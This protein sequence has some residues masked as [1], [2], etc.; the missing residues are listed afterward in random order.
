MWETIRGYLTFTRKERFGV[1]FLLLIICILFVLP[2]IFRRPVGESDPAAYEKMKES[3]RNFEMKDSGRTMLT[4]EASGAGAFNPDATATG[5]QL[6]F[7]FDPN[8][9][10]S[11]D[12]KRLGISQRLSE[13]ITRYIE[14]GGRFRQR[15]DLKKIYGLSPAD[16]QR[17]SPFVQIAKKRQGS[18]LVKYQHPWRRDSGTSIQPSRFIAKRKLL[19]PTAINLADTADWAK[20]P[21][22]GNKLAARI[23]HF[24]EKLGGFYAI[25]QVAETFGLPDS[26]FQKIKSALY[27]DQVALVQIDLNHAT[28]ETLQAHPYIRWQIAKEI[29]EYRVQHGSFHTVDQLQMLV[30]IDSAKFKKIRPYVFVKP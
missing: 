23:V 1:L 4:R 15:E 21:G 17:L 25:Q 20:L 19:N 13:T 10:H 22:I 6:L 5:H 11:A 16:Y 2:Y 9:I 28:K 12:W 30:Q 18:D 29:V 24:R 14:K 3:I 8:Q 7:F 27:V 26:V